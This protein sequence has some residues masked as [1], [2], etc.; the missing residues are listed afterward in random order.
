VSTLFRTFYRERFARREGEP[1]DY[2]DDIESLVAS[3]A[4]TVTDWNTG[5]ILDS[6][7]F[8]VVESIL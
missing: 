5:L 4:A 2:W 6:R 7:E 1:A 8:A 3:T